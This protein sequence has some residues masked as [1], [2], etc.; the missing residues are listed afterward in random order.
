MAQQ[1][2]FKEVSKEEID[3]LLKKTGQEDTSSVPID[4][5]EDLVV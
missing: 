1:E 4:L 3:A 5:D 2:D